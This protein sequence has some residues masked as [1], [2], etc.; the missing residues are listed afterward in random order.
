MFGRRGRD[1]NGPVVV[2]RGEKPEELYRHNE[3]ED[4][5][6]IRTDKIDFHSSSQTTRK[7][8]ANT[9][10]Q[11]QKQKNDKKSILK[12]RIF[13]LIMIIIFW[14]VIRDLFLFIF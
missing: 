10:R 6:S 4:H 11:R 1:L 5:H 14:D 8:N 2:R 12:S 13:W 3:T 9:P 7:R